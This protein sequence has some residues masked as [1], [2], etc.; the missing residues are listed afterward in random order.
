MSGDMPADEV[1]N[2]LTR[3]W[4]AL[5]EAGAPF[6]R[7]WENLDPA[8]AHE[9]VDPDGVLGDLTGKTVLCL[10]GGG[11]QQSVAYALLGATVTV[12]DLSAEQLERDRAAAERYDVEVR[13]EQGDIRDLGR[14]ADGSFDVVWHAYSINF[15]PDPRPVLQ[16]VGRVLRTG[17]DYVFMVANPFA[18][19]VLPPD[20]DG[21]GYPVHRPYV[22]GALI[23]F[24][25]PDWVYERTGGERV[26]T[27]REYRHTLARVL[28]ELHDAGLAVTRLREHTLPAGAAEPGTWDH[29]KSVIPPWFTI[30]AKRT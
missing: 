23:E 27:P 29:F 26:P 12:L 25:D 3:R 9:R 16:G 19:G 6:T 13:L 15:V 4:Q 17:G 11:G 20:W 18:S 24:D 22:D 7:P 2:F 30:W 1:S 10:A 5:G 21:H 8:S 14:F 28:D